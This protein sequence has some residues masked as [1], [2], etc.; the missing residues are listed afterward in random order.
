MAI[1]SRKYDGKIISYIFDSITLQNI[2]ESLKQVFKFF[3]IMYDI[4]IS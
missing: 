3:F 4:K 2:L 1:Y